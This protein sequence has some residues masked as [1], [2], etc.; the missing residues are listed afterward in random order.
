MRRLCLE[1]VFESL[2][3]IRVNVNTAQRAMRVVGLLTVTATVQVLLDPYRRE[4]P[5]VP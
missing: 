2:Q 1:L 3:N 4:L 5:N